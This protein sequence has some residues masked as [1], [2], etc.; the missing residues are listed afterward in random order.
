MGLPFCKAKYILKPIII[1]AEM[2]YCV[3]RDGKKAQVCFLLDAL[4]AQ[5]KIRN[6][7]FDTADEQIVS[8]LNVLKYYL[9]KTPV[10]IW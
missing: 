2:Q 6:F 8:Q 4:I 9:A 5:G 10:D 7:D 1:Q 3:V